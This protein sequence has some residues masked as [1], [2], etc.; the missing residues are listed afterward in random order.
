[1]KV[2]YGK[3]HFGCRAHVVKQIY[4]NIVGRKYIGTGLSKQLAVVAT[5]IAYS[6]RNLGLSGETLVEVVGKSLCGS[7]DCIDV[8]AVDARS[9]N[10][11]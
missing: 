1:M 7:T 8:H 11:A 2:T 4:V 10:A 3:R 5:I 9:H 6:H